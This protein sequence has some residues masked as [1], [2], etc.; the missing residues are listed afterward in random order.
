[1]CNTFAHFSHIHRGNLIFC[2]CVCVCAI[3]MAAVYQIP[4]NG[5]EQITRDQRSSRA[6]GGSLEDSCEG[7]LL[8]VSGPAG[9]GRV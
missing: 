5:T 6:E 8:S 1:M 7:K 2:A 3:K 9:C 4:E